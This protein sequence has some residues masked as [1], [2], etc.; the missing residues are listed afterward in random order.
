MAASAA[1]AP[2]SSPAAEQQ[3]LNYSRSDWAKGYSSQPSEFAYEVTDIEGAVPA[4]LEGTYFRNGPGLFEA[5]DGQKY[6]H[7]F[8]GDGLVSSVTLRGGK[9]FFR[10]RYVRTEGYVAERK[11]GKILYRNTFGT[12]RSGGPLANALDVTQKNVA[13][14]NVIWWGGKLLALWE[15]LQPTAL[16]PASLETL[17]TE[18]LSGVLREGMPFSTGSPPLDAALRSVGMPVG[19]DPLSAHPHI[20]ARTQRLVTFGYQ[21]SLAAGSAMTTRFT[22]YEFD[23]DFKLVSRTER[24]L[25]GFA[26]CHDFSFTESYYVLF[27][28]RPEKRSPAFPARAITQTS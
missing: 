13:N 26:F 12:Q 6:A 10:A 1:S 15:A 27:Q 16:D 20:D 2:P 24:V 14:T 19:G 3:Q 5:E 28:V 8:D 21:T 22:L 4:S 9:A 18:T 11:A 23:A 7:P 17:G 25:E